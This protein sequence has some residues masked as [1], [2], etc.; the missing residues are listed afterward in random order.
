MRRDAAQRRDA[1]KP[2][3]SE[4]PPLSGARNESA[5]REF[6]RAHRE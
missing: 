3:A 2:A 4:K 1:L 6:M 5:M